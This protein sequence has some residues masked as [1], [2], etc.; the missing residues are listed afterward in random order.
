MMEAIERGLGRLLARVHAGERHLAWNAPGLREAP[1]G[2]VLTSPAF[3]GGAP[4]PTLYAGAG[5]GD[6][7]SPPLAWSNLPPATAELVLIMQ[8]PDAPIP[9]PPTHLIAFAIAPDRSEIAEGALKQGADPTLRL[10]HGFFGRIGYEGP[11]PVRGHGPHR[12]VF[13]IFAASRPLGFPE[14]PDL[15]GVLSA[16]R[17]SVLARGRLIGTYERR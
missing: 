11:R 2:I 8:D 9:R 7:I 4:M 1:D 15:A 12:Y 10:G 6:N 16:L 3:A 17:Q 13:Q 14:T 5:A